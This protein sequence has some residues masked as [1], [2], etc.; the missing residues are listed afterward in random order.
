MFITVLAVI[1]KNKR[2]GSANCPI[3]NG[4]VNYKLKSGKYYIAVKMFIRS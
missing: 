1:A 2:G 3:I 4:K